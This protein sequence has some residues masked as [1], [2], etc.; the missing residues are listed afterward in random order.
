[1]KKIIT[2]LLHALGLLLFIGACSTSQNS[3]RLHQSERIDQ[4]YGLQKESSRTTAI[5]HQRI[6]REDETLTMADLLSR[7]PGVSVMGSGRNLVVRIRARKSISETNDPLFV[8][9]GQI[10]GLGFQSVSFVDPFMIDNISILKDAAA[11]SQYGHRGANGVVLIN[12]KK[13]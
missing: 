10:M 2:T 8:I 9:N 12:L 3:V 4:G 11:S 6:S 7:T 13:S 1:M 5:S